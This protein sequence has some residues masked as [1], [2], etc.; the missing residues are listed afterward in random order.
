LSDNRD[1]RD[2]CD[3]HLFKIDRDKP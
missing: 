1:Y 2:I 3:Y